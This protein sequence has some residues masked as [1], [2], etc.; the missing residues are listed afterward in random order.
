MGVLSWI[1]LGF[2]A[3]TL[4]NILTGR[5]SGLGC[6]T[7]VAVG[8]IG[9]FVGGALVRAGGGRAVTRFDVR[10]VLVAALGATAFLLVLSAIE[11][12]RSRS[13]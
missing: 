9:A 11:G 6:L 5:R 3:G 2:L 1:V 8:M 7:K 13:Q 10:S 12:R 4:A